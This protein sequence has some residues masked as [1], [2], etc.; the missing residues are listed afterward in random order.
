MG[1]DEHLNQLK[2]LY[3]HIEKVKV[4]YKNPFSGA[5]TGLVGSVWGQPQKTEPNP[6]YPDEE[7]EEFISRMITAKK[8]K[9]ERILDLY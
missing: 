7:Y 6:L 4:Y 9:I 5:L 8:N 1:L 2:E 3:E